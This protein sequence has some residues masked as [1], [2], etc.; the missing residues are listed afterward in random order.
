MNRRNL[1]RQLERL[2]HERLYPRAERVHDWAVRTAPVGT[3]GRYGVG[4]GLRPHY[5][6][7]IHIVKLDGGG[8]RVIAKQPHSVFL[9][10]GTRYM[11]AYH[12]LGIALNA[13]KG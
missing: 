11:R 10:F 5:F 13:A 6:Q 9:E 8:W 4:P 1:D 3:T 7:D 12:T 2:A